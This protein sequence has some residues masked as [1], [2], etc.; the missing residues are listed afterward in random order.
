MIDCQL[1]SI[2]MI[3]FWG[4]GRKKSSA[5]STLAM[6]VIDINIYL[7]LKTWKKASSPVKAGKD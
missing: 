6:F 7:Y 1:I 2:I 4:R 5:G 3:K